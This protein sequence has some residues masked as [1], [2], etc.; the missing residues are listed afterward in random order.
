[1]YEVNRGLIFAV[2][3]AGGA[4]LWTHW[5]AP[6][7]DR[8]LQLGVVANEEPAQQAITPI[9]RF[10]P[11]ARDVDGRTP[12]LN[13][14]EEGDSVQVDRLLAAGADVD[15]ADVKGTT[16]LMAGAQR[17]DLDL[18][19]KLLARSAKVDSRDALGL[20]ALHHAVAAVKP[21]VV[22]ILLPLLPNGG[23]PT[24]DGRDLIA[25]ACETGDTRV[26]TPIFF[27]A[28]SDLEW[29][30][31]TTTALQAALAAENKELTRLLLSRHPAPPAV[32]GGTTPLLAYAIATDD[33]LVFDE[34]LSAGADPNTVLPKPTEKSFVS[35]LTKEHLREYVRS[36]EGVT[37]LMVAAGLGKND[38]VRALLAA[39]ADKNCQTLRHKMLA[40]YFAAKTGQAKLVQMLLG[41]GPDPDQLRV[42]ISLTTQRASIIKD[43]VSILK[44]P[45]STG[46]KGFDTPA[47]EFV[48]THKKRSHRSSLYHVAMPFFLRLNCADFGLH[49]GAVPNYPASHGCIRLPADVAQKMFSEVPIGTM[50]TIN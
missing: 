35:L 37:V 17:G 34:L 14:T 23:S 15:L 36:D 27:R 1:M 2:M 44:T 4:L 16:P 33:R 31:Q 40:I 20:S 46:R 5:T 38:Y 7:P 45:I 30:P 50:V 12:L 48:V 41:R 21:E 39:G 10:D 42:E 8:R 18:L 49:A 6:T 9:E 3:L 13:A 43:G 24:A 29:T 32:E 47:G 22:E 28:P 11:N 26:M 25:M 19:R